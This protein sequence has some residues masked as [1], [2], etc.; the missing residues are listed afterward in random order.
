MKIL[1]KMKIKELK[2]PKWKKTIKFKIKIFT[3]INIINN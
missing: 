1:K 3:L 2:Q